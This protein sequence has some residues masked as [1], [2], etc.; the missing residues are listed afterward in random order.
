MAY[1]LPGFSIHGILQARTLEWGAIS[2]SS[3]WKWKVKVKVKSLSHVYVYVMFIMYEGNLNK[4]NTN[5][6][7][8]ST[9]IMAVWEAMTKVV[10]GSN[11]VELPLNLM[12]L[13]NKK[14]WEI[15]IPFCVLRNRLMS[16]D[17]PALAYSNMEIASIL[18]KNSSPAFPTSIR[19]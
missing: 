7:P 12:L 14:S 18:P 13:E 11:N 8:S 5:D 16:K 4:Y 19:H 6:L 10:P 9:E 2:F 17:Y 1:S 3:A 15:P